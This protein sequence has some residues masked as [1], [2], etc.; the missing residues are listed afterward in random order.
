MKGMASLAIIV[1]IIRH[2]SRVLYDFNMGMFRGICGPLQYGP[3][4]CDAWNDILHQL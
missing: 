3:N 4:L 2:G 1:L